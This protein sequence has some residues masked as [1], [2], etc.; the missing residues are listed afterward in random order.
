MHG[1]VLFH[2]HL[3]KTTSNNTTPLCISLPM[4]LLALASTNLSTSSSVKDTNQL[5]NFWLFFLVYCSRPPKLLV[6]FS[7]FLN[8]PSEQR[9]STT[10]SMGNRCQK[11]R[12]IRRVTSRKL[13]G[14]IFTCKIIIILH[15]PITIFLSGGNLYKTLQFI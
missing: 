3:A 9:S 12:E 10:K 14:R 1:Y 15:V 11:W 13:I 7:F 4:F 8:E 2:F 5:P 6:V